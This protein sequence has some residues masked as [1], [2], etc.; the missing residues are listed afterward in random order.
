MWL[1]AACAVLTVVLLRYYGERLQ[2][3]LNVLFALLFF[4]LALLLTHLDGLRG[5]VGAALIANALR[6]LLLAV[7]GFLPQR[8]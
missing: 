4:S 1:L 2:L 3:L 8:P 7:C 6:F 5:F